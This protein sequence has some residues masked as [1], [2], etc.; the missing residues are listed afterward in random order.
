MAL[1]DEP[2]RFPEQGAWALAPDTGNA[3][4]VA[5]REE[6]VVRRQVRA[7]GGRGRRGGGFA[8]GVVA[9]GVHD[10]LA[11][12]ERASGLH[13]ERADAGCALSVA[14]REELVVRRK[15]RALRSRGRARGGGGVVRGAVR[16][17][18]GAGEFGLG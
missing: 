3:L 17:E 13:L 14:A 18:E 11:V 8:R 15:A 10:A 4:G 7:G 5:V 9:R 1:P 16:G 2:R 12:E 6:L